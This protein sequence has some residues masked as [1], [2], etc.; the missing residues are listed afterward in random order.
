M[1][2]A[3]DSQPLLFDPEIERSCRANRKRRRAKT[4]VM[5]EGED[6]QRT[7]RD[8]FKPVVQ[9]N[10]SGIQRQTVNANNFEL[11]PALVNMVQ[12][13]QYGGL[14]SEDPNVH[15][16]IFLEVCDTVKYNGVDQGVIRLKL[17]PFSLRDRARAW[18]QSLPAGSAT[19]WEDMAQ[20]FL[21]KFFPPSKT[22]QLRVEITQFRQF[23]YEQLY[24]AWERFKEMLRKCPQHGIEEW[25]LV[26][27]FY[28]G[29]S[30][31]IKSHIDASSGRTILSKTPRQALKLF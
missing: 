21:I 15:L 22:S 24:E 2:S 20:K 7:L 6:N 19:S 27:L 16:A 25:L 31:P 12:Q 28:N 18:L 10:Y 11:K 23:D 1:R 8:Y 9:D 3:S 26:Q 4:R 17:F 29:L 5:A 14:P 30:G 13:N